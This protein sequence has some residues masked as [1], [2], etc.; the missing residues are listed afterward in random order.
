MSIVLFVGIPI[1]IWVVI[2]LLSLREPERPE[3]EKGTTPANT[4]A[5][6]TPPFARDYTGRLWVDKRR[7][8]FFVAVHRRGFGP[9]GGPDE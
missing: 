5:V 1:L 8:G 9:P 7:K 4:Y 3:Q 6:E 2:M